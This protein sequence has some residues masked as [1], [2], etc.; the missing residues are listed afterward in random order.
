[1]EDCLVGYG[2]LQAK[3]VQPFTQSDA[4]KAIWQIVKR[5]REVDA[6]EADKAIVEQEGQYVE[7]LRRKVKKI[8]AWLLDN[9]DKPGKSMRGIRSSITRDVR[10]DR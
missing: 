2:I 8:K 5:H 4:R 10:E 6:R 7:T 1:M 9:D 3:T